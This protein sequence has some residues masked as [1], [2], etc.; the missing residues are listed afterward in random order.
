[1]IPNIAAAVS[2][3]NATATAGRTTDRSI[4]ISMIRTT[5]ETAITTGQIAAL[6][7][8]V[9]SPNAPPLP[10]TAISV[11]VAFEVVA[12][13][14]EIAAEGLRRRRRGRLLGHHHDLP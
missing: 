11:L 9:K 2:R 7:S 4:A 8:V 5:T 13:R 10:P 1:M 14:D 12:H 3:S 6:P